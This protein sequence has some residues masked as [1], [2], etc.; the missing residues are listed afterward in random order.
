MFSPSFWFIDDCLLIVSLHVRD[1]G[2]DRFSPSK[3]MGAIMGPP[4]LWLITSYSP[5]CK[6][7]HI[8]TSTYEFGCRGRQAYNPLHIPITLD[9]RT[10]DMMLF[11]QMETPDRP[12]RQDG[13]LQRDWM[14]QPHTVVHLCS[15]PSYIFHSGLN[16]HS[17]Q[18]DLAGSTE[19]SRYTDLN[20][21]QLALS[22]RFKLECEWQLRHPPLQISDKMDTLTTSVS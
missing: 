10:L 4:P 19:W 17:G 6:Y 7:N 3:D 11:N 8:R 14:L 20:R 1:Q 16:S 13:L 12:S 5:T 18:N 22:Q 15:W 21:S 2:G 9:T